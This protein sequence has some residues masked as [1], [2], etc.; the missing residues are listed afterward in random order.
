MQLTSYER[1][2]RNILTDVT[3]Y[4]FN[5]ETDED[6]TYYNLID[7]YGDVDGDPFYEFDDLVS[8]I[9]NNDDVDGEL[10]NL[11]NSLATV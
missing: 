11:C 7:L 10:A 6:G 3:G 9:S 2:V 1:Q 4:S 8:Y 5:K